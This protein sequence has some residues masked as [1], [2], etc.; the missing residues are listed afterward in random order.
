MA[1]GQKKVRE[2]SIYQMN[3]SKKKIGLFLEE[4]D[5]LITV[6]IIILSCECLGSMLVGK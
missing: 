3:Q 2:K 5:E 1:T 6:P 4:V